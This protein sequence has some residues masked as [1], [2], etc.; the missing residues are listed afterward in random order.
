MA[1]EKEIWCPVRLVLEIIEGKWTAHIIT[2]LFSGTKRHSELAK[3]LSGINPKTLTDRLRDL[4]ES[5]IVNRKMYEE[6]PPRVEYSL[7]KRGQELS[8]IF[9]ALNELGTAWRKSMRIDLSS[10]QLCPHCCENL[11]GDGRH[12]T[13]RKTVK[14]STKLDGD[15]PDGDG[16]VPRKTVKELAT[17]DGDGRDGDGD[18][19]AHKKSQKKQT[20]RGKR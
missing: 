17:L 13:L 8:R 3:R 7:T 9:E 4:E 20:K 11:D 16:R 10:V 18:G 12:G 1:S 19:R 6:I 15:G 14:P 2:E 5:G